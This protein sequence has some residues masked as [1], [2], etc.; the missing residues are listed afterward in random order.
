MYN[1]HNVGF[2]YGPVRVLQDISLAIREGGLTAIVGPNGAGKSSLLSLMVG[3][4]PD[5]SGKVMLEGREIRDWPKSELGKAIAF[6]PQ[7]VRID[8]PFTVEQVVLMGR[9]PHGERMFETK[10]DLDAAEQAM[11][12]TDVTHL[13]ARDFRSL[14]GGERQRVILASALAQ[15]PR[16]LLLDEPTTF[17]DLNHQIAIYELIHKLSREGLLVV[18]ITHDLQ[19]ASAYSDRVVVLDQGEIVADGPPAE[20]LSA[21]TIQQIFEVSP[22]TMRRIYGR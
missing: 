22:E 16:A 15:Q 12:L 21:M 11:G 5:Y 17:L 2:S 3:L 8:F 14:S 13:R 18:A 20:A 1:L 19:L 4:L 6:L 10:E 9:T 7:N